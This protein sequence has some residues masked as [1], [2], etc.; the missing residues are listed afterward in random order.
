MWLTALMATTTKSTDLFLNETTGEI[1]CAEHG[2]HHLH[3]AHTKAPNEAWYDSD[4]GRWSR[5]SMV[6]EM[7]W[8]KMTGSHARCESCGARL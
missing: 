1:C 3:T 2:G 5:W 6:D 8:R 4:S 7:E